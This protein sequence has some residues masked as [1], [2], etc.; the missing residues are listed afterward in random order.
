MSK[1]IYIVEDN[2]KN[3][4]LFIAV[5]ET[6]PDLKIFT[7]TKGKEG[8]ELIKSGNPDIIILDIQLPDI[9][10]TEICKELREIERFKTISI[11]AVSSLAMK[12][13]EEMIM[14]A[15]FNNYISKPIMIKDFRE[16]I[17]NLLK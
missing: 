5:L 11:I 10:G 4:E 7:A 13:D 15:G 1:Q 9:N 8:L 16:F 2:R 3:M 6:L 17:Q 12:G 14:G